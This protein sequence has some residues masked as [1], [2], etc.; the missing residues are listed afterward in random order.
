MPDSQYRRRELTYK[1]VLTA[2]LFALAIVLS[3]VENIIT[4][5]Q[6]FAGV[7]L[8]L[9]NIVT[10]YCLFFMGVKPTAALVILKAFFTLLTRGL[11]ASMLALTGGAFSVLIML[12]LLW[13][14]RGKISYLI[15]SVAGA[16]AHNTG[17][18]ILASWLTKS[19]YTLYYFPILLLSGVGAGVVT[20]ITLRAVMPAIKRVSEYRPK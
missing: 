6:L 2:I 13:L 3:M 17:Q 18:L 16:V 8:G 11:I 4:P 19:L 10:M 12:L 20:G 5:A 15:I 14:G 7:K 9:S 1:I